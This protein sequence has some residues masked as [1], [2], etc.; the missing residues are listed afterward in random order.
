[1]THK[2]IILCIDTLYCL[3]NVVSIYYLSIAVTQF[4]APRLRCCILKTEYNPCFYD[5]LLIKF[6]RVLG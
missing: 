1:M 5:H 4:V 3:M 2:C 6:K